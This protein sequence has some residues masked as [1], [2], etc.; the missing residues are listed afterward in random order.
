MLQINRLAELPLLHPFC[1]SK[2]KPEYTPHV[3]CGD[4]VII[5]NASK[6]ILTGDKLEQKE[7]IRHSGYIGGLKSKYK[8]LMATRPERHLNWL[9][10]DAPS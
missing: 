2:H 5:I 10:W 7:Y 9:F 1:A 4:H 3:D 6:A 8:D